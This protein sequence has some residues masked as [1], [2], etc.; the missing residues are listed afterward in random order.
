MRNP[1]HGRKIALGFF[2][3]GWVACAAAFLLP[4]LA[5]GSWVRTALFNYGLS[6]IVFGGGTAL[7]RHFDV[8]AKAALA[9]GED[10]IARWRVEPEA[11]REFVEL[12]RGSSGETDG[13]PNELSLPEAVPENGVEVIAGKNAVQIGESIHR[14]TGGL[15]EV[16]GGDFDREPAGGDRPATLLSGRWTRRFGRPAFGTPCCFAISSGT[17]R[18]GRRWGRGRALSRGHAEGAGFL[19]RQRRRHESEGPDHVL[20]LRL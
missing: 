18:V 1:H 17:R 5:E 19:P 10:I 9:R 6:A 2:A 12:D 4:G 7:F 3:S 11:W 15:P 8:R 20:Q 13:L 16:D 14:L